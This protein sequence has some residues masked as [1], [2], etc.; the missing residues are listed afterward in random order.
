MVYGLACEFACLNFPKCQGTM[1]Q[2][3]AHYDHIQQAH[4]EF[5]LSRLYN[6]LHHLMKLLRIKLHDND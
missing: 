4:F 2:V 1:Q 5:A 6:Q 3:F